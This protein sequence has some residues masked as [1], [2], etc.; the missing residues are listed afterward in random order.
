VRRV[1]TFIAKLGTV[2]LWLA[3]LMGLAGQWAWPLE[4]FANFRVQ[5]AVLLFGCMAIALAVRQF[6]WALAAA[7]SA[8]LTTTSVFL[9]IGW[10]NAAPILRE[11]ADTFRLITFN[12]WFRNQDLR[13]L[14]RY[15][16]ASGADAVVLLELDAP[17]AVQLRKLLPSYRYSQIG[18]EP[19]GAV[20]LSRWPL[21]DQRFE[22]LCV[23]CASIARARLDWHG[24][25]LTLLGVHLHWPLGPS[26]ARLRGEE[27][28]GLAQLV[29][30]TTQGAILLGGDFNLTPWSRYFRQFVA[31]SG[32]RDC[33][34]LQGW[35]PTW[36]RSPA[37]LGIRIDQC[38]ASAAWRT[39]DVRVGPHLG[40]DHLPNVVDLRLA[41]SSARQSLAHA[42]TN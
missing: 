39:L 29:G 22:S 35:N 7:V 23:G 32:L 9:Y 38:F 21:F 37:V 8:V 3:L 5:Y 27:L 17:R 15:L 12:V 20:M 13:P 10:P 24:Q 26:V 11:S 40:S 14:A 41:P 6:K 36:P 16:E 2:G 31:S 42:S 19:H 33:A 4:L 28:Q 18:N 34:Q 1:A 25:Q 30:S